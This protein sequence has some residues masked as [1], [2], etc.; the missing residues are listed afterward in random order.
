MSKRRLSHWS[1]PTQKPPR[2]DEE[3][4]GAKKRGPKEVGKAEVE[5]IGNG[6]GEAWMGMGA[7]GAKRTS[8]QVG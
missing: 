3:E 2:R 6:E 1:T 4:E 8:G 5:K 7:K